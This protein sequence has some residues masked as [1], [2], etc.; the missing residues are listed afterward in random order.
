[1]ANRESHILLDIP[2]WSLFG[3]AENSDR[4]AVIA[5]DVR[6]PVDVS[7]FLDLPFNGTIGAAGHPTVSFKLFL[8]TERGLPASAMLLPKNHL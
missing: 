1:M 5:N 8:R 2:F 6:H 4:I 7:V 3:C